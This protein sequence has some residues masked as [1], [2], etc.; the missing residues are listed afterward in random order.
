MPLYEVWHSYPLTETQ[1]ADLAQRIT[2]IHTTVFTVPAAF[3]HVTFANY[4]AT[5]HYTGG[6]KCTGNINLVLGN[7]RQGPSRTRD[8]YESLCRQI[9]A[10]WIA[11]VGDPATQGVAHARLGGA[12]VMGPVTAAYEQGLM[13]PEAGQDVEW[14]RGNLAKFQALA[15]DGNEFCRDMIAELRTREDFK[16]AFGNG[17]A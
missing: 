9:E 17:S 2:T 11:S 1:R 4:A 10:A 12:F 7:V 16:F 5:E 6:K 13:I 3:V 8:L 15:D 14:V